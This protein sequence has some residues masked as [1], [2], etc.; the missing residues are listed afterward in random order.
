MAGSEAIEE[1]K[2]RNKESFKE[3]KQRLT[4]RENW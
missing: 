3:L 1:K 4:L 2:R